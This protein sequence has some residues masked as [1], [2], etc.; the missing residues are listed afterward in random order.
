MFYERSTIQYVMIT[1]RLG[2]EP[3][4]TAKATVDIPYT[5]FN[6]SHTHE[7]VHFNGV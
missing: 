4:W 2:L 7:Q 6:A 5:K 1:S 3:R